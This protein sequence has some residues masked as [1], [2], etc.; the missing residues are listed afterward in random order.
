MPSD[1]IHRYIS[2]RVREL[3]RRRKWSQNQLADFAGLSRSQ[4]SRLMN[5]QQSPSVATLAKVA[6][7]LEVTVKELLPG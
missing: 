7:A 3:T 6:A 2:A 1:T 5:C 4:L